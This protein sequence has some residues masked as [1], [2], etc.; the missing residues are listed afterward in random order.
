MPQ[1]ISNA[2][3]ELQEMDQGL[4]GGLEAYHQKHPSSKECPLSVVVINGLTTN[5]KDGVRQLLQA[6][7]DMYPR[8]P[9]RAG[10]TSAAGTLVEEFF[11]ASKS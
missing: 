5:W 9:S 6:G 3:L 11:G 8:T 10:G 1:A 2:M 4:L 7:D